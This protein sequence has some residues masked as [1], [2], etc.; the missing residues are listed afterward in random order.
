FTLERSLPPMLKE[1]NIPV[2][3]VISGGSTLQDIVNSMSASANA[4]V[5][6]A[7]MG[8]VLQRLDSEGIKLAGPRAPYGFSG[9]REW[10][11]SISGALDM[12]VKAGIDAMENRYMP[13]FLQNKERLKGKKVF[14]ADPVIAV[15]LAQY[16]LD[17]V[18]KAGVADYVINPNEE[19][20]VKKIREITGRRG[21]NA[22]IETAGVQSTMTAAAKS[23]AIGGILSTIAIFAR[24]VELPL[25]IMPNRNNQLRT[26]I[27][28]CAGMD[29]MLE[30]IKA[31]RINTR[32]MQTHRSPLNDIIHALD[33]FGG[34]KDGCIKYLITPF[35]R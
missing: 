23:L 22:A 18:L 12:D 3:S 28:Q 34:N 25:H 2:Q 35:E 8:T 14:E 19:D 13:A 15:D 17:A 32:F 10:L 30:E 1:L 9:T 6:S 29:V 7:V 33:I 31:G 16:R 27:Q 4:V 11:E 21:V 26:G 24:P 5:C 20:A